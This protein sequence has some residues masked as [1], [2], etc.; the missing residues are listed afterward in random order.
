MTDLRRKKNSGWTDALTP[1]EYAEI[2]DIDARC[3]AIDDER[4]E[5]TNRRSRIQ[6]RACQRALS[7]KRR[8]M[9]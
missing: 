7:R 1:E 2:V 6:Q 3:A 4:K 8:E 9:A 5:L